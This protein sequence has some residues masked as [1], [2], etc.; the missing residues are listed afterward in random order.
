MGRKI[1]FIKILI[2]FLISFLLWAA[3]AQAQESS[4]DLSSMTFNSLP[5]YAEDGDIASVGNFA[6][7]MGYDPQRHWKAGDHPSDVFTL[8]DFQSS[9]GV[10]ELNLDQIS[11]LSDLDLEGLRIA[12]TPFLQNKTLSEVVDAVPALEGFTLEEIPAL[13]EV[14]DFDLSTTLGEMIDTDELLGDLNF[15]EL[16]GDFSVT[17][18]PNLDLAE[19]SGFQDW[20][21]TAMSEVPGL[22][23]VGFGKLSQIP[24]IFSGVTATHDVTYGPKEH[25]R[26]PTKN[27]ITGSNVEGFSVQCGQ[28]R[29]CAHIELEGAGNMHGAQWIA[30][31]GKEGQQMVKGGEGVLGV[32]NGG[33]EPTG[34]L[35]FGD[36]FKIVLDTTNESEGTAEF[37]LYFRYCYRGTPDLGCTPYFL[38]PIPMPLLDS[39]E[40]GMVLT[41]FLDALGGIT[42][43]IEAPKAWE[44]L[45][46][47]APQEVSDII[48]AHGGRSGSSFGLCGEGPGGVRFESLAG[49]FSSIEGNYNSVGSYTNGGYGLGRYQYMTYRTD[50]RASIRQKSGGDAFLAK[51]DAGGYISPAEVD[52]YFPAADQDALF[53]ADQTRNIEQAVDEGFTGSRII[54]RAGQIHYGGPDAPIDGSASDLH[55]RLTLKTYG[56][57]LAETY[58]AIDSSTESGAKCS[59]PTPVEPLQTHFT[60]LLSAQEYGAARPGGRLH[61]GQDFDLDPDDT[62][63]SYIGGTVVKVGYDP[64]G[65]YN[66]VDIY[67]AELDVVE[68]VAELDNIYIQ[69]GTTIQAGQVIGQ[70]THTTGVVHVEY[71]PP[72][73]ESNQGGYGFQGTYNPIEYLENLGILERQGVQLIPAR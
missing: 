46:P 50:V 41:G 47:A 49:A 16:L 52:R 13:A 68:R 4:V 38:G 67:N 31:G 66:Y 73:N 69:E 71:R 1:I 8:G 32:V 23:D 56:E 27:S 5:T 29:G 22:S 26:T 34:R 70:G 64:S 39:K 57:E 44:A 19:L 3:P 21:T 62:F 48:D 33:E 59:A 18:I 54:E 40:K 43:G 14:V 11:Q 72:V 7:E 12:D 35:P 55:G 28:S 17:E 30:G 65:Y 61:A 9:L 58:H 53:K 6:E 42:S 15:S 25:T 60:G 10:Q 2:A 37:A 45:K 63:Q 51:A 20:Q 36:T 24:D